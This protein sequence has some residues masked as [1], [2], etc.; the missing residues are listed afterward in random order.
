MVKNPVAGKTKTR[1]AE[2]V[3]DEQAV[4]MYR[5]L[6]RYTRDRVLGLEGVT[7]YLHYSDRV[8]PA[9][10]WPNREFIKLVQVGAGLGERMA[11]AIDHAFVRGHDKII[12]I[13]SDC[14]G[15]TTELLHQAFEELTTHELVIGPANDGGYYLIGMRHAHPFL[16]N[17]MVWSTETVFE[18]T[19]AR[20]REQGL[21]VATLA[22]LSDVDHLEDWL[23]YG[24]TM[25]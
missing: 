20:A 24:W 4:A 23:G 12:V 22:P 21:S 2:D 1:L 6:M 3:G 7:R 11:A 16:F 8:D 25:P 10:E 17:N 13:G 14:P 15:V 19:M 5:I 18:E 9:D